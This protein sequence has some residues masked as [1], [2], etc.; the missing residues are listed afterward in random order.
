MGEDGSKIDDGLTQIRSLKIYEQNPFIDGVGYETK[1]KREIVYDGHQAIINTD[2][3]QIEDQLALA[4][5]RIVEAEQFVKIYLKNV[6]LL[7]DLTRPGQRIAEYLLMQIGRRSMNRGE[8]LIAFSEY[9]KYFGD[10]S[11]GTRSTFSRGLAELAKK[12]LIARSPV[13]QVWWINPAVAF[14][15]DRARFITEIRRSRGNPANG[16]NATADRIDSAG[17]S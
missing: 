10:R 12:K 3:G 7:F 9:E 5:I 8:V 17:R 13:R 2:T 16:K 4:R 1:Q 15:G 14:N 11:G 6:G